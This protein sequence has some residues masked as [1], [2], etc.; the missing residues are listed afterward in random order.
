M[1]PLNTGMKLRS[2][3]VTYSSNNYVKQTTLS[4]KKNHI[5]CILSV[6]FFL[7]SDIPNWTVAEIA[8]IRDW[9]YS[10]NI[11]IPCI[12]AMDNANGHAQGTTIAIHTNGIVVIN[13]HGAL[14]A[15]EWFYGITVF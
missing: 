1:S 7:E 4:V 5:F 13:T 14:T 2:Y 6:Q 10:N 15:G 12:S 3:T 11:I 8:Q 9:D